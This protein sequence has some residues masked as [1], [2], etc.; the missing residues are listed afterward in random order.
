MVRPRVHRG[1]DD[2]GPMTDR[3]DRVEGRVVTVSSHGV[4]GC[5]STSDILS[6]PTPFGPSIYYD[7]GAPGLPPSHPLYCLGPV[8][9][10]HETVRTRPHPMTLMDLLKH[11]LHHMIHMHML[12]LCLSIC[13]AG[14]GH[15]VEI[16]EELDS[17]LSTELRAACYIQYLL[18]SSLFIDKSGNI[19]PAKL[20]PIVK[21]VWSSG[22]D[23]LV[24]SYVCLSGEIGSEVVQAIYPESCP[25]GWVDSMHFGTPYSPSRA[26][27]ASKQQVVPSQEC[28]YRSIV[29][30]GTFTPADGDMD[31]CP[32]CTTLSLYRRL[33]GIISP[34]HSPED[35]ES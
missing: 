23:I 32:C 9:L 24:I 17:R 3:T 6:T 21:H 8:L 11:H 5:H 28:V 4:R 35:T 12:L 13:P 20:W 10:P 1:D 22:M 25:T 16:L 2:L 14:I 27:Q 30:G 26:P 34:P 29:A 7:P 15:I 19:V 18:G 33:H 31:Q